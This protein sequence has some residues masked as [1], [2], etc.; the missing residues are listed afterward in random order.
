MTY[1]MLNMPKYTRRVELRN[2][3][4]GR[5]FVKRFALCYGTVV[6]SVCL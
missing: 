1:L 2:K 6:L 4:F 3:I 5:P